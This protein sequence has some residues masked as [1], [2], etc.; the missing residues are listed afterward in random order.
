MEVII[1]KNHAKAEVN[2]VGNVIE[3][4]TT[5][6]NMEV[7]PDASPSFIHH[8]GV[9]LEIP[10]GYIGLVLP[11]NDLA[12]KSYIMSSP[13]YI[14]SGVTEEITVKF[15]LNTTAVPNL[16]NPGEVFAR[17]LIIKN[18]QDLSY[19]T[20]EDIKEEGKEETKETPKTEE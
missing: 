1:N 19:T 15:K 4:G 8:S 18:D 7:N 13:G 9:S 5:G 10:E 16:Y 14:V 17:V 2:R 11:G 6:I 3:L 20:V 12:S